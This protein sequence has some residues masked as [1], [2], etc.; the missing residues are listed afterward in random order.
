MPPKKSEEF[1]LNYVLYDREHWD[2]SHVGHVTLRADITF[3]KVR[4]H[5]MLEK[6]E[7]LHNNSTCFLHCYGKLQVVSAWGVAIPKTDLGLGPPVL[8]DNPPEGVRLLKAWSTLPEAGFGLEQPPSRD[9]ISI[10][11]DFTYIHHEEGSSRRS[12]PETEEWESRGWSKRRAL[13]PRTSSAPGV[14]LTPSGDLPSEVT[15]P[16]PFSDFENWAGI[17]NLAFVD[18]TW[19]LAGMHRLMDRNNKCV[20]SHPSGTGKTTFVSMASAYYNCRSSPEVEKLFT[21]LNINKHPGG[22]HTAYQKRF[23]CLVFNLPDTDNRSLILTDIMNTVKSFATTY[24]EELGV[25]ARGPVFLSS[26]KSIQD[27]FKKLFKRIKDMKKDVFVVV[28]NC[29]GPILACMAQPITTQYNPLETAAACVSL[30]LEV[31]DHSLGKTSRL[32]V[33]SKVPLSLLPLNKNFKDLSHHSDLVGAFGMNDEE[34]INLSRIFSSNSTKHVDLDQSGLNEKLGRYVPRLLD[35]QGPRGV[36]VKPAYNFQLVLHHIATVFGLSSHDRLKD[37]P[38]LSRIAG[39]GVD[40]LLYLRR[41]GR[42][43]VSTTKPLNADDRVTEFTNIGRKEDFFWSILYHLGILAVDF[44]FVDHRSEFIQWVLKVSSEHVARQLF[45]K[46]EPLSLTNIQTRAQFDLQELLDR[47]PASLAESIQ[48]YLCEKPLLDLR[49]MSEATLQAIIDT[50]LRDKAHYFPQLVLLLDHNKPLKPEWPL[51]APPAESG[52]S[53]Y[54]FLDC[55]ITGFDKLRPRRALAMELKYFDLWAFIQA[56]CE[57]SG[58]KLIFDALK[59]DSTYLE[60][61][62]KFLYGLSD[63]ELREQK[64]SFYDEVAGHTVSFTLDVMLQ[65]A[66][67]QLGFY[68]KAIKEGNAVDKKNPKSNGQ[69]NGL[70]TYE[71]RVRAGAADGELVGVVCIGAGPRVLMTVVDPMPCKF[72][73]RGKAWKSRYIK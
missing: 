36:Y 61:K 40:L 10:I 57:Q 2:Q 8:R 27:I 1:V 5:S 51:V 12:F 64:V 65:K 66:I 54:G 67:R 16:N 30:L 49:H 19:H 53:R 41:N 18:K 7:A 15:L 33:V 72:E 28:D 52:E 42:I 47:R 56:D 46:C 14:Y 71:N 69:S 37:S 43:F 20:V 29:D 70:G 63:K 48:T 22:T 39:L 23:L 25:S 17:G 3:S 73:F 44:D 68:M 21:K 58:G 38:L 35:T 6:I 50:H 9:M 13:E 34:V 62:A 4:I 32:L 11:A 45:P 59:E 24:Q 60:N 31:L 55:F 26:D